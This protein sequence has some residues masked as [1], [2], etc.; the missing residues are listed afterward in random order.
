MEKKA[1]REHQHQEEQTEGEKKVN[2]T[3]KELETSSKGAYQAYSKLMLI[4]I[5]K[6]DTT[7]Y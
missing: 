5:S 2:L 4:T 1:E 3:P 7:R 6:S